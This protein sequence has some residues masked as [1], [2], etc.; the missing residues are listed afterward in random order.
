[1]A[2]RLSPKL[3]I[4]MP[5]IHLEGAKTMAALGHGAHSKNLEYTITR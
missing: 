1:M 3:K 5:P 4:T 2:N